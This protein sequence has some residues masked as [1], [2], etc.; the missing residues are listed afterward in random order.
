MNVQEQYE[1][2]TPDLIERIRKMRDAAQREMDKF[3]DPAGYDTRVVIGQKKS[4]GEAAEHTAEGTE[5]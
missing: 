2:R 5:S 1:D 4:T 3:G